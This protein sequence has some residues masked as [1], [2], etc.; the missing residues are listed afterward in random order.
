[1]GMQVHKSWWVGFDHVQAVR[2]QGSRTICLMADGTAVP[3]SRLR[4]TALYD[5]FGKDFVRSSVNAFAEQG[6]L[7]VVSSRP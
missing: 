4:Q 5:Y 3:V 1:M 2:R 6:R 7:S